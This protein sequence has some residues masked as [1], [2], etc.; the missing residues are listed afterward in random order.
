M[1]LICNFPPSIR[2]TAFRMLAGPELPFVVEAIDDS[3]PSGS[4]LFLDKLSNVLE[5]SPQR[6]VGLRIL[7]DPV[8]GDE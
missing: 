5:E 8:H 4:E 1:L 2:P 3:M 6:D 7:A